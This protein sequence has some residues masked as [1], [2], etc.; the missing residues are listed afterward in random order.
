MKLK[1]LIAET[2]YRRKPR[3]G[4]PRPRR[5][6]CKRGTAARAL[7]RLGAAG[8]TRPS[9]GGSRRI[10]PSGARS[11]AVSVRRPMGEPGVRSGAP[12]LGLLARAHLDPVALTRPP[13]RR[14][15]CFP[16]GRAA[17]VTC[18]TRGSHRCRLRDIAASSS[19]TSSSL[20]RRASAR[21]VQDP[22]GTP[23]TPMRWCAA[24]CRQSA[25][26]SH[27]IVAN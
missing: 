13:I 3:R 25:H 21:L 18:F 4:S 5:R 7:A 11:P 15:P 8:A 16:P 14:P 26:Y 1:R 17:A 22:Q 23:M 12:R 20:R 9:S 6:T 19:S 2:R 10:S 27:V 24:A